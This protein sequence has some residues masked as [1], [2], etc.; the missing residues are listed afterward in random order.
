MK[1]AGLVFLG[2]GMGSVLRYY[3]GLWLK[4]SIPQFPTGT[5]VVNVLGA[6]LMGLLVGQAAQHPEFYRTHAYFLWAIGFCGGF[7]TFSAFVI[8][9]VELLGRGQIPYFFTYVVLSI[10]VGLL[11]GYWSYKGLKSPI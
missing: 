8:D 2:G 5:F 6:F 1:H 11:A 7:T 10:A 9:Q 4:E 3:I